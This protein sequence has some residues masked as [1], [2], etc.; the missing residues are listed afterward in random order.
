MPELTGEKKD[1]KKERDTK[2]RLA[3]SITLIQKLTLLVPGTVLGTKWAINVCWMNKRTGL[4]KETD[5]SFNRRE[6]GQNRYRQFFPEQHKNPHWFKREESL[7]YTE[8]DILNKETASFCSVPAHN[9]RRRIFNCFCRSRSGFVLF[10]P[11]YSATYIHPNARGRLALFHAVLC[12]P[13]SLETATQLQRRVWQNTLA[14]GRK[15]KLKLKNPGWAASP[16]I[17]LKKTMT[18]R[19][20]LV[21]SWAHFLFWER[22]P[23]FCLTVHA[24]VCVIYDIPFTTGI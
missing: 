21:G 8:A 1:Q 3:S 24:H 15:I 6:N 9:S 5:R 13:M 20:F 18:R 11:N 2:L 17:T 10:L 19:L 22:D 12:L 4:C 16:P 23:E 14:F 7:V